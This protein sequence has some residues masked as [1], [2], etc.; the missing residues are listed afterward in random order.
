MALIWRGDEA[1]KRVGN[2]ARRNVLEA[3]VLVENL[4]KMSMKKGGRTESGELET[5]GYVTKTGGLRQKR[6]EPGTGRKA[7]KIGTYVSKPGEVPRVQF[8]RLKGSITHE[9]HPVLPIG[10]VGT[11][12]IYGKFLELGTGRMAPRP[13]MR[14]AMHRAEPIIKG[15]FENIGGLI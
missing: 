6:V 8:A 9:L 4:V 12:V 14:P 2:R 5:I 10:R 11:N 1:I 15:M 13:F 3:C 7:E